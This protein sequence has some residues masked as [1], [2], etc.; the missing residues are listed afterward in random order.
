M[1]Y[2]KRWKKDK[3]FRKN[4]IIGFIVLLF[5]ANAGTFSQ[6]VS[7]KKEV[8]PQEVCD[9]FNV[10]TALIDASGCE[11]SGCAIEFPKDPQQWWNDFLGLNS[12]IDWL[13]G[14]GQSVSC[15]SKVKVGTYLRADSLGEA[16]SLCEGNHAFKIHDN[17]DWFR[18]D[19]YLCSQSDCEDW[20]QIF[21]SILDG[22]WKENSISECSTKA[23]IV[24]G[25][26]GFAAL[27]VI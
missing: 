27:A 20:Q 2:F 8:I 5:L 23:Y 26:A 13:K 11:D 7:E 18:R 9:N 4:V 24:M 17:F 3:K 22:V 15:R 1:T 12:L 10:G 25:F 19:L 16:S 6:I 21:A 14:E